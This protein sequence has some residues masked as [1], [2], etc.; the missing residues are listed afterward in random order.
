MG[1]FKSKEEKAEIKRK[2]QEAA[3]NAKAEAE[4]EA[5]YAAKT[6]KKKVQKLIAE[7]EQK[8]QALIKNA[9][10]AKSKGYMDV[11]RT[12]I[13][14]I[15][16]A[17]TRKM[18]AEKFLFQVDA[19]ETMKSI[20]DSSTGLL[21]SMSAIASTLG[22][23][24]IDKAAMMETQKN[25]VKTQEQLSRQNDMLEEF[26]ASM[27]MTMDEVDVSDL[28]SGY[29]DLDKLIEND[30]DS[31]IQSSNAGNADISSYEQMLSN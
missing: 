16:V 29:G 14:F 20:S 2:Q 3:D 5:K 1:L 22:S 8:E 9:A 7:I 12:Q 13:S 19:M 18:Q 4:W 30:I 15:K 11:Y 23:L 10:E 6:E 26:S 31:F 17:R 21:N 28:E 25:F 27:E 24:T